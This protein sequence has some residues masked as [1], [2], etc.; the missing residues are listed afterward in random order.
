M[1][2]GVVLYM[3]LCMCIY[4]CV[5]LCVNIGLS[6]YLRYACTSPG[7]VPLKECDLT[8]TSSLKMPG[9]LPTLPLYIFLVRC[10]NE[11]LALFSSYWCLNLSFSF[12]ETVDVS[13]KEVSTVF[14]T[15]HTLSR[16]STVHDYEY[17]Y[18]VPTLWYL[19]VGAKA[20]VLCYCTKFN[21]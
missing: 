3:H 15:C 2:I 12:L 18:F 7:H 1:Y 6:M 14:A 17:I 20:V 19:S 13:A 5:F 11:R 9:A 21:F 16:Y 4:L 10:L 8:Y